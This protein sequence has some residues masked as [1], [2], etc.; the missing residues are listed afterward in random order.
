MPERKLDVILFGVTGLVGRYGVNFFHE[1]TSKRGLQ[2]KWGIAGRNENKVRKVLQKLHEKTKDERIP[3]IPVFL[4]DLQD[5]ESIR[6]VVKN[7]RVLLNFCGPLL[8]HG[9]NVIRTCI[10]LGTHYLDVS[11][12]PNFIEKI[13]LEYDDQARKAG[14]YVSNS[15]GYDSLAYDMGIVFLQRKMKGLVNSVETYLKYGCDRGGI[16]GP[17]F[18]TSTWNSMID[19]L[20]NSN[21]LKQMRK[22]R[23]E[24][25][26]V[27][28]PRL[29]RRLI[30][31]KPENE[32]G[33]AI[34]SPTADL[35]V[36]R[37]TQQHRYKERN[38]RPVQIESYFVFPSFVEI[39]L[40]IIFGGFLL[41][42][43]KTKFG[44]N[45]LLKNP[46]MFTGGCF[47]DKEPCEEKLDD[48]WCSL[49]LVGKGWKDAKDQ[50]KH[51]PDTELVARIK[52]N[53]TG[54]KLTS[55]CL[56]LSGIMLLTEPEK[57]PKRKGV[58]TP[59]VLLSETSII[60]HLHANGLKFEWIKNKEMQKKSC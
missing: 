45:L 7:T 2:I 56:V 51:A 40:F 44:R 42:L 22:L 54:Y 31:F 33:W 29:R 13:Q 46:S 32:E 6:K 17:D 14:V 50:P 3:K 25:W 47:S 52:G 15:C 5:P 53:N 41:L 10:D 11:A 34:L 20:G 38:A 12:E 19:L 48:N 59:G 60:E 57:L 21:E 35:S 36:M 8:Q 24:E 28:K 39:I 1:L 9:E 18:N 4:A 16:P 30:P 49:I 55:L 27:L 43:S 23:K 26:P 58:L 37:R